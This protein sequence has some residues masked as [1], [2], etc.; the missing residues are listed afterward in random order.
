VYLRFDSLT[1]LQSAKEIQDENY[2]QDRPNDTTRGIAPTAAMWPSGQ[3][4]KEKEN[5]YD[6]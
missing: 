6:N 2:Y 3:S 4:A 5:E 1:I